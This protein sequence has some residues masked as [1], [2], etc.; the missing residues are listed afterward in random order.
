MS[1]KQNFYINTTQVSFST[2]DFVIEAGNKKDRSSGSEVKPEDLDIQL[3][4]SPQYFKAFTMA[5]TQAL[6]MYEEV[7]GDINIE[8][9]KEALKKIVDGEQV[10]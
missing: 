4:M 6:R 5:I 8:G 3:F 9:N 7:Y 1:D 10:Q 2:N